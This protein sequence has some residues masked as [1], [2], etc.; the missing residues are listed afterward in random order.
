M[1]EHLR[2]FFQG[3]EPIAVSIGVGKRGIDERYSTHHCAAFLSEVCCLPYQPAQPA[4]L[5]AGNTDTHT[6]A[7]SLRKAREARHL[8]VLHHATP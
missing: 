3:S 7:R 1:V 6:D 2:D 8:D 5:R 4:S